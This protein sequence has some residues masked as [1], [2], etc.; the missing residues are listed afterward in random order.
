MSKLSRSL[1]KDQC[2]ARCGISTNKPLRAERLCHF[3]MCRCQRISN[4]VVLGAAM[5]FQQFPCDGAGHQRCGP[6]MA[7]IVLGSFR[8]L[9][10]PLVHHHS[11]HYFALF[12][13]Y[14]KMRY[15]QISYQELIPPDLH[16]LL[17]HGI[18]RIQYHLG[19][20]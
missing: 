18:S 9:P 17:F 2:V 10:N 4:C 13:I 11:R 12:G 14:P 6:L 19:K 15:A 8:A 1:S 7:T 16:I 20:L 3:I 5:D